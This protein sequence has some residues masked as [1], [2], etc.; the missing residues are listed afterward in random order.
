MKCLRIVPRFSTS[1]L[2]IRNE[3]IVHS[4]Q[5]CRSLS[6]SQAKYRDKNKIYNA[7]LS[8]VAHLESDW[9]QPKAKRGMPIISP[10]QEFTESLRKSL[11]S[12][13][14]EEVE[15]FSIY[16]PAGLKLDRFLKSRT[17]PLEGVLLR[18]KEKMIQDILAKEFQDAED[19]Q[20]YLQDQ[21]RISDYN[22]RE[23]KLREI[24]INRWVPVKFDKNCAFA[25]L[26]ARS[27]AEY[28]VLES[29][30]AE[31]KYQEPEFKAKSFF[32]YGSGV[33]TG[34]W[35]TCKVF[36]K[37]TESYCVDTSSDMNDLARNI[38]LK[39]E[40]DKSL[41]IGINFRLHT[42]S[43]TSFKYDLVLSAYSLM[44][45]KSAKERLELIFKLW[46]RVEENG[47]LVLVELGTNAGFQ[48]ISEAR[49]FLLQMGDENMDIIGPCP[50][51][52][53]CPRYNTD[54]V[55]CNFMAKYRMFEIDF[56]K[57]SQVHQELY[58]YLTIKKGRRS[59]RELP[60]LVEEPTRNKMHYICRVCTS[61]GTLQE[62]K[63]DK[64]LDKELHTF[65]K[66]LHWGDQMP[67]SLD[68]PLSEETR[69]PAYEVP[70]GENTQHENSVENARVEPE[71]EANNKL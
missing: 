16:Y 63:V 15:H 9:I 19:P 51:K 14:K 30:F 27:S 17:L 60:R 20:S 67:V 50:Q 36:G 44:E 32:D 33:G 57:K 6:S 25:Y 40:E 4:G 1:V 28:A 41:P 42:P 70:V 18:R 29:I 13:Y 24:H 38:I 55:P 59:R 39:G 53:P 22:K 3:N 47:C 11:V 49:D 69:T 61:N 37:P 26:L 64:R 10:S 12:L 58:S 45:K 2:A 35:A 21:Q 7:N 34:F 23:E 68:I 5:S 71:E 65:C 56:F 54:N 52:L 46:S 62:V 8:V 66:T 48:I 43:T 31:L